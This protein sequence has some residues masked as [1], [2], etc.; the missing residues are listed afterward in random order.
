MAYVFSLADPQELVGYVRGVQQERDLNQ[1]ALSQFLPNKNIDEIEYR[2]TNGQLIDQDAAE[3]RA[4]DVESPIGNRQG[5]ARKMGE[6]PPISKKLRLGEE[7][8]LRLR[9]L[10]RDGDAREIISEIYNDAGNLAR[11]VA[12][13]IEL[14]RGEAL[15]NGS[16]VINENEVKAT[17]SFGRLA[18]H[19]AA[20]NTLLT[21]AKWDAPTTADP[22][23][24]IQD[25]TDIYYDTNGI[26]PALALTSLKTVRLLLRNDKIRNLASSLAGTPSQISRATLRSVLSDYGLPPIAVYDTKVRV[27][28]TQTRVTADD[29]FIL[30]PPANEPMGNT[31]IGTTAEGIELAQAQQISAEDISGLVAVVE[32][33]FDPVSTWTKVAAV[34]L[35]VLVN[36]NLSF[37]ADVF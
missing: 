18:A 14:F 33:T 2:V 11:A 36:P 4:W 29:K 27:N 17:V 5:I 35:P 28:G 32:K 21:T 6:L 12:A 22:I 13:R 3:V 1:F 37:V 30:L 34:A 24:N 8:R 7:E 19:N 31:F 15:V 26:Q 16:L 10:E 25:W 9:Q 23:Q 20:N